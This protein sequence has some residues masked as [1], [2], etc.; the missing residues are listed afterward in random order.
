VKQKKNEMDPQTRKKI[1][2]KPQNIQGKSEHKKKK[3]KLKTVE[4]KVSFIHKVPQNLP[5][6]KT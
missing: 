5:I 2:V 1:P 6:C 4:L 3:N